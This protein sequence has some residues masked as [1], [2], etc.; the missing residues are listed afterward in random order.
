MENKFINCLAVVKSSTYRISVINAIGN[1][2]IIPSEIS[3]KT[4][5]RLN[6]VSTV[7]TKLK[8]NNIVECLNE[9]AKKGRLYRLTDLGNQIYEFI[10]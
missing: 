1:N 5:L 3:K 8:K 10:N 7:L 6:H 9:D 2:I 4:N